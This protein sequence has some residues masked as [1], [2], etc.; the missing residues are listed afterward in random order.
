MIRFIFLF[1]SLACSNS[2]AETNYRKELESFAQ[3]L[4]NDQYN[5]SFKL[6]KSEKLHLKVSPI[7]KR[8]NYPVCQTGLVGNIVQNEIKSTTSVKVSC[9]DEKQWTTYIRVRVTILQQAVVTNS[10]LSKGQILNQNNIKSTYINKTHIRNGAHTYADLLYGARLKRNISANNVIK[11]RDV[12]FVCK[13]DKVSINATTAGLSIKAFGVA[14]SDATIGGTVRVK[15]SQ[16]PR[17]IVGTVYAL[18]EVN[19]SF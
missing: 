5:L 8:I 13:G 2:F 19:V 9:L 16:T 14:L 12:C 3:T 17:I 4:I 15:N 11:D 18:K 6:Q 1:I 7:D 10:S